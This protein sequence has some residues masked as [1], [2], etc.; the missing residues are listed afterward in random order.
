MNWD[1]LREQAHKAIDNAIDS[2]TH[3]PE[4]LP[5]G[6][7][8]VQLIHTAVDE[9]EKMTITTFGTELV[10]MAN[11]TWAVEDRYDRTK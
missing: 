1:N 4:H 7:F 8:D 6:I 11:G 3:W 2:A 10:E 9:N 5:D